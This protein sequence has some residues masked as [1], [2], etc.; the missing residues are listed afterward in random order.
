MSGTM[1]PVAEDIL[2]NTDR[3]LNWYYLSANMTEGWFRQRASYGAK[4]SVCTSTSEDQR[5]LA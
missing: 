1:W 3:Y 2:A 5:R 4:S